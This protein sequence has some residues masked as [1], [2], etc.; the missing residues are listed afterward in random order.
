MFSLQFVLGQPGAPGIG[1]TGA[2][3]VTLKATLPFLIS[4]SG[5]VWLPD[6][7]TGAGF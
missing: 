3:V 2:I 4:P 7:V 6:T 5:I 1:L